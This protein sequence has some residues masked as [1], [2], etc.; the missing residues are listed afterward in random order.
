MLSRL[1]VLVAVRAH[2]SARGRNPTVAAL[3]SFFGVAARKTRRYLDALAR[4]GLVATVETGRRGYSHAVLLTG[5][6]LDVLDELVG[7]DGMR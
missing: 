1:E 4:D 5:R 3:T 2:L 6:G 7:G